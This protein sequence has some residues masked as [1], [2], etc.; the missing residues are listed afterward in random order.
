VNGST[1]TG[2]GSSVWVEET[3]QE[4]MNRLPHGSV[5]AAIFEIVVAAG[6]K[7]S[8]IRC[9]LIIVCDAI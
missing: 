3:V 1:A 7:V 4:T 5:K 9:H 6:R 8:A 2:K